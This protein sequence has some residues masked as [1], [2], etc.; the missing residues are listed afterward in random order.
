MDKSCKCCGGTGWVCENCGNQWEYDDGRTCCGAGVACQ[1]NK[2]ADVDWLAV[3]ASID[4][5]TFDK[6]H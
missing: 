3:H 5:V 1:C 6:R 2:D 4:G